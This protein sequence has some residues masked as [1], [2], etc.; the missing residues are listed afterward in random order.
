MLFVT[1]LAALA[2][3]NKA[4]YAAAFTAQVEST[5]ESAKPYM[6]A[7]KETAQPHI[8]AALAFAKP[9][10]K[11]AASAARPHLETAKAFLESKM[12]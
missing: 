5:V 7:A 9:Y 6:A 12:K 3:L 11:A 4:G 2:A 8:D 1:G 10:V